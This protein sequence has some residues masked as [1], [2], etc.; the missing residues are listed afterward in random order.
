MNLNEKRKGWEAGEKNIVVKGFWSV[1]DQVWITFMK[2]VDDGKFYYT[3]LR[4]FKIG[5]GWEVS[6][7][8]HSVT[9][10]EFIEKMGDY[11]YWN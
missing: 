10:D 4:Y 11:L 7:D 9:A 5:N 8:V 2:Q 6:V 3:L 1:K